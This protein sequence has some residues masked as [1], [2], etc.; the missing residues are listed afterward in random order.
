[1]TVHR[2]NHPGVEVHVRTSGSKELDHPLPRFLRDFGEYPGARFD[3]MERQLGKADFRIGL[4]Q[5]GSE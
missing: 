1:M 3:K 5:R 4:E 2:G